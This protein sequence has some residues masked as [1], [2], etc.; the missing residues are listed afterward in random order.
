MKTSLMGEI[1]WGFYYVRKEGVWMAEYKSFYK[2]V[3]GNE[4]TKCRY[5]TRLDSYGCGC[6][7][8]CEY[9]YARS[10]LEFRNMWHPEDPA[11]ADI[12]KIRRKLE[13]V[14]TGN[15]PETGR[16]DGLLPA[17]GEETQGHV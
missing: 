6:F 11:V 13:K 8:N 4:G 17:Y 5:P 12:R 16:H 14:E 3:G 2:T 10:L 7:H 1:P 9:C 15:H